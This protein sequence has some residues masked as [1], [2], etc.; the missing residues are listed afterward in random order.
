MDTPADMGWIP[1]GTFRMGS[2]HHYPEEGPARPVSLD[3]FW[4]DR[5]PVTNRQFAAF[6]QATGYVTTA[7]TPP[8]PADYPGIL[9]EMIRAGSLVFQPPRRK[10]DLRDIGQW[11]AFVPGAD[12][13]HPR[14]AES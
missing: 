7:E 3:G 10:V 1:A 4:I 5:T 14:G 2:D 12:W 6:V 9:P 11:W 8:D 13:R